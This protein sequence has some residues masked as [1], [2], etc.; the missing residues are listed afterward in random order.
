MI[1]NGFYDQLITRQLMRSRRL[2]SCLVHHSQQLIRAAAGLI[3]L[4]LLPV[5][6]RTWPD[7]V[8]AAI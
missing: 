6:Q 8:C 1:V 4:I 3:C 7:E 2:R 5:S